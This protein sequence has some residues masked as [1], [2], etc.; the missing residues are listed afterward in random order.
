MD[1]LLKKRNNRL[2]GMSCEVDICPYS[3]YI[4]FKE[5]ESDCDGSTKLDDEIDRFIDKSTDTYTDPS[6]DSED[7]DCTITITDD[8]SSA[9]GTITITVVQ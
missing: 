8:D 7:I 5:L 4:W 6:D 1:L 2:Y 3:L 9:C